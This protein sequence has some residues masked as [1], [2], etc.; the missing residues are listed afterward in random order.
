M[1]TV[2]RFEDLDCWKAGRKLR[3]LA[4]RHTR[5]VTFSADASLV[6]QVRRAAQSVTANIAEGFER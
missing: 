3:Q 4:Y 5:T 6:D 1:A 2:T